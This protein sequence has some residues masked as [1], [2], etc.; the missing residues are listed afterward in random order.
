M[1]G[2]HRQRAIAVAVMVLML[3]VWGNTSVV[4]VRSES[5]GG[6][7]SPPVSSRYAQDDQSENIQWFRDQMKIS[8]KY[9]EQQDGVLGMSWLHFFTMILLVVFSVA[10]LV[11]FVQRQKRTRE[12]LE[13]IK[14]EVNHGSNG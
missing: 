1:K 2:K 14:K 13:L 10:A 5:A 9:L 7:L 8:E 11:V 12:I 3:V 4:A 6:G